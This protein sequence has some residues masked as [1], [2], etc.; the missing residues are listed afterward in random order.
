[1]RFHY[2][3]KG[4]YHNFFIASKLSFPVINNMTFFESICSTDAKLHEMGK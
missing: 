4:S 2:V 1:M 3:M